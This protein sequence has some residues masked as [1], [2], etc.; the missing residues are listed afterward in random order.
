MGNIRQI[1]PEGMQ[2][3][4][5]SA[6]RFWAGALQMLVVA[7]IV[8]AFAFAMRT[9]AQV[10]ALQS[11]VESVEKSIDRLISAL[12]SGRAYHCPKAGTK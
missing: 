4:P 5:F 2:H 8:G 6:R 3:R 10:S 1:V 12:E 9:E 7:A 11:K